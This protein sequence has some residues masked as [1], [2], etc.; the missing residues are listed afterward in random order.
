M[1][2]DTLTKKTISAM[3]VHKV[4]FLGPFAVQTIVERVAR[5]TH[6]E[7]TRQI[8]AVPQFIDVSPLCSVEME[9]EPKEY[10][11]RLA[12]RDTEK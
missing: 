2:W 4:L 9:L 3:P 5:E 1:L 7:L 8:P 6:K 11:I 10:W 12:Q